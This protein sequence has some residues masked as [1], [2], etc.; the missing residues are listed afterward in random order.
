MGTPSWFR[1]VTFLVATALLVGCSSVN[2]PPSP[3][4][5]PGVSATPTATPIPTATVPPT[6]P[7]AVVTGITN[8]KATVTTAELAAMAKSG[9]LIVPCGVDIVQPALSST[10]A[11]VWPDEIP[12]TV[13]G[14]RNLVALIPPGLVEP[15]TKVLPIAGGGP[16]GL[17]GPDLFGDPTARALPYPIVGSQ[18]DPQALEPAWTAYDASKVWTLTELGSLCA[19]RSGAKAAIT[20]GKGWDYIFE[21]GT[22]R[23]KRKP[24]LDPTPAPGISAHVIVDPA[25]TGHAGTL[26]SLVKRSDVALGNQKCP[27]LPTKDWKPATGGSV[28]LS[29]PEDVVARWVEFFGL[30]A[31]YLPADHQ[32]D[33]GLTGIRSTLRIIDKYKIP[34]TGLGLNLDEALT[35]AYVDV[36]GLKVAFVSWNEVPGPPHA[37]ADSAGVAWLTEAN[38]DASVKRAKDGG[39]DLVICDPQWWGGSEYHPDLRSTQKTALGW[40]DAAGC[41]QILAGG[42]HV[43]GTVLLREQADGVSV[44]DTGP[45]NF[46]FGQDWWQETQEGVIVELTFRGKTLVNLR[47]HPYVMILAARPSLLDPQGDGHYVLQRIWKNAKIAGIDAGGG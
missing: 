1:G 11:C 46:Q 35:P 40:M 32:G 29:V 9:K 15:R 12:A 36:A 24:F 4:P 47:L 10:R 26:A 45:G 17:F 42:L 8:L 19:D 28:S 37:D 27:I 34:R 22:A 20:L 23:Y 7:L 3:T 31:V 33:R 44:V 6:F 25:D 39:A 18:Q 14:D 16:F 30:D 2:P 13:D 41:D 5:T 21:G 38:V 43:A